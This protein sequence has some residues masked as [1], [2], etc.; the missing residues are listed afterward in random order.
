EMWLL[1]LANRVD[2]QMGPRRTPRNDSYSSV[3]GSA[4]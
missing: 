2:V 1:T 3:T 4:S